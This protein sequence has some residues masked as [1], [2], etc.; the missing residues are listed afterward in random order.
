MPEDECRLVRVVGRVQGVSYRAWV[1]D[2]AERHGLRGWVRNEP[3]GSVLALLFGPP[4]QVA[5]MLEAMRAG[6]RH[7][8]VAALTA[9]PGPASEAPEGFEIIG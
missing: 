5:R 4:P 6:P 2:E 1:Q 8:V 3:D 7:A 9:E